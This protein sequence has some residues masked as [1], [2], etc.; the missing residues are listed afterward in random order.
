MSVTD[1]LRYQT[2]YTASNKWGQ[3]PADVKEQIKSYNEKRNRVLFYAWGVFVTAY[4]RR[5]LLSGILSV[6]DDYI[7]SVTD[8][9]K[10][11]YYDKN[12]N[13]VENYNKKIRD[14]HS[15]A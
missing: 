12:N 7:Y 14:T 2:I 5:N 15:K 1:I 4:A 8:S 6:K 3:E 13:Y 9:I 11:L 10:M